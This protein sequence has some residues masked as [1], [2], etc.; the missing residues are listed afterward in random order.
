M[1]NPIQRA[2]E[3]RVS[4]NR[5]QSGRP[6]SAE[7]VAALVDQATR[8][9]SAYNLQNWRFIA[10]CSDGAKARLRDCA[11]GQPKVA[12]ASV[13]FILCGTLAAHTG[14]AAVLAP[15]VQ[16][17]IMAGRVAEAWVAQA[18]AAHEHDPVL[19]RDEAIRSASLAAMSLVL[20]A[21]GTGLG[22]CILGGFDAAALHR[23]FGLGADEI[24][25]ALV[26]VGYPADGNWPQKPRRPVPDVLSF[27]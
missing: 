18:R 20:A 3:T 22:S 1:T 26:T 27:A 4:I 12:E 23:E 14:L 25:V 10:V 6:L 24:P 2:L 16:A 17:G 21:Q 15:S 9:P 8:A 19:Q 5:F 7:T 11:Y 13:A